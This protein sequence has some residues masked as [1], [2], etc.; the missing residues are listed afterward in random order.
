[1]I[2]EQLVGLDGEDHIEGVEA[3]LQQVEGEETL[4]GNELVQ[5]VTQLAQEETNNT[6]N[7]LQSGSITPQ[8]R[9]IEEKSFKFRLSDL[10]SV[11][12]CNCA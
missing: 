5:P 2:K 7:N 11:L 8:Q 6:S 3:P 12:V 1:M 10:L 9:N 4:A